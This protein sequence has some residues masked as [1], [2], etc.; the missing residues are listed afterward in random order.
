[1]TD[2]ETLR[3]RATYLRQLA[4]GTTDEIARAVALDLALEYGQ[5]ADSILRGEALDDAETVG[6]QAPLSS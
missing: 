3:C 1:M 5:Q 4:T 6:P 2:A